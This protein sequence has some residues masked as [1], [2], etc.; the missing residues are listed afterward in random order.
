MVAVLVV[1]FA[2]RVVMVAVMGVLV[3]FGLF[4]LQCRRIWAV[5]VVF[6]TGPLSAVFCGI[7]AGICGI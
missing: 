3:Q 7:S 1:L 5:F 4:Y 6:G 2:V